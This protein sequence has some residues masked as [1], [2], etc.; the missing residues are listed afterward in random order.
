MRKEKTVAI[1]S[2]NIKAKQQEPTNNT[3]TD[4][5]KISFRNLFF[6]F[7]IVVVLYFAFH[8]TQ[9][10]HITQSLTHS[11]SV[12]NNNNNNFHKKNK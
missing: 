11:L 12:H 6:T 3:T 9:Y 1:F 4:T 8:R 2:R 10:T 7:I 5:R